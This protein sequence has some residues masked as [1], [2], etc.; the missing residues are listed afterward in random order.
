L[1]E[2]DNTTLTALRRYDNIIT[3]I[4]MKNGLTIHC[5]QLSGSSKW[6]VCAFKYW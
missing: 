6:S 2:I 3:C 4:S 5:M 1:R